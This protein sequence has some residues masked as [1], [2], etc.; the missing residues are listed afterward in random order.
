[1]IG[2]HRRELIFGAIAAALAVAYVAAASQVG[3]VVAPASAP[4]P[5]PTRPA[6]PVSAP[7]VPGAIAF[8]LRGDV[9]VLRDGK[10]SPLTSEGRNSQP[11]LSPDGTT[12]YFSRQETVDGKRVVDE[13]VVN[14]RLAFS[15]VIRKSAGGGSE[16]V[17][18]NGLRARRADGFHQV[19]WFLGP[20]LSPDGKRLA[21][22]EDDGDGAADLVIVDLAARRSTPLS[23]GGE[24][25]DPS[26]SPDGKTV[27]VT[28]Y[29]TLTPGILLWPVD[30]PGQAQ[31][32]AAL[33]D[34]DAYRPSHSPDGRWILYTLRRD[35]RNDLHAYELATKRD[36]QVTIDGRS[37]NGVFSPDGQWVAFLR[38]RNGTIDLYAMDLGTALEG[39]APREALKLTHGEGLDGASRPSWRP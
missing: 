14:A 21:I 1:V 39:G 10:Y 38:E 24:L 16:E 11:H 37:W 6:E 31:R 4:T 33:P 30:R 26:W 29:N 12:L 20:A 23:R 5:T 15:S 9:Y 34:G 7:R 35:G 18:L 32:L 36:V 22:V 27:A 13:Q 25:A 8:V 3:P 19:S 28:T 2:R 17:V